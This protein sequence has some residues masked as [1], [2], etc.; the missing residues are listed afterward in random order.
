M[1]LEEDKD[2]FVCDFC[3][4]V[5]FPDPNDEGVRVLGEA[6][7]QSCPVCGIPLVHAAFGGQR[8]RY[9]TR[10]RGML[11]AMDT[12]VEMLRDL[13]DGEHSEFPHPLDREDLKRHIFCPQC[14]HPMDTHPYCGPGNIVIDDCSACHLNWLDHGEL[15]RIVR[16]P[17]HDYSEG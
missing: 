11:I 8:I 7:S 2:H 3:K 17:D 14:G 5:Y 4:N 16:A 13:R 6:V 9:C 12:F 10:C 15:M 1:R